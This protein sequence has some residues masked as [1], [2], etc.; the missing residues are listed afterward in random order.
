MRRRCGTCWRARA[1]YSPSCY[2]YVTSSSHSQLST[3]HNQS[4][5]LERAMGFEPTTPTLASRKLPRSYGRLDSAGMCWSVR[6]CA[7][8]GGSVMLND[9]VPRS[10]PVEYSELAWRPE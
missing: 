6:N 1:D 2:L 8:S 9:C 3:V 10:I 5:K 4:K 7:I